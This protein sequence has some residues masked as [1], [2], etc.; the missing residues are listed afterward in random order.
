M[1][2]ALAVSR[3]IETSSFR[4]ATCASVKEPGILQRGPAAGLGH[5]G[6][7][8]LGKENVLDGIGEQLHF[9]KPTVI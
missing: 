7:L 1:R 9:M 5:A 3:S 6:F 4:A 2:Q 8:G